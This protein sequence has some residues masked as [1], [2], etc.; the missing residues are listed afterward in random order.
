V[1]NYVNNAVKFSEHGSIRIRIRRVDDSSER[2]QLCFEVEDQGIGIAAD[3]LTRLFSAF[4]QADS[5]TTR[6]Y[7]G[8]GLGLALVR[9]LAELM[10]GQAGASS[11]PGAG[12]LFWFTV[13]LNKAPLMASDHAGSPEDSLRRHFSHRR[14]LLAEDEPV[15]REITQMML[16]DI[17]DRIDTATD[18]CQA[19]EQARGSDYDLILMDMQMPNMDGLE[20]TRR[21]RQQPELRDLPIVAMTANAFAEDRQACMAAG[22]NDFISK[23]VDPDI[24]FSTLA[25]LAIPA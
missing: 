13:W 8:T 11:S 10:G 18:G 6:K 5:S 24:L 25:P 21:I 7:G 19:V 9:K 3:H 16:A 4:E 15:N 23:P 20:A 14:L 17:F 1:L 22:M 2:V 12:S